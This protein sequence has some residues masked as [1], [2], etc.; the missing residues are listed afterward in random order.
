[1]CSETDVDEGIMHLLAQLLAAQA[2]HFGR[3]GVFLSGS[4]SSITNHKHVGRTCE[5]HH[6]GHGHGRVF[7]NRKEEKNPRASRPQSPTEHQA[8]PDS[9]ARTD[10]RLARGA[11]MSVRGV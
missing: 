1:M 6:P 2:V 10:S 11:P 9:T 7:S 4:I 3:A 8:A 5:S